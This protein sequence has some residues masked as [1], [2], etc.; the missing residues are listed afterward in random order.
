M[1]NK[2]II[3]VLEDM[4]V[5]ISIPKAAELQ[6]KRNDALN[7]AIGALRKQDV[8]N[9]DAEDM[10]SRQDAISMVHTVLFPK[11]GL[12]KHVGKALMQLPP[13]ERTTGQWLETEGLDEEIRCTMCTNS[14]RSDSGCD[15]SCQYDEKLYKR[16][17]SIIKDHIDG[18]GT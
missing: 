17:M 9:T 3:E 4:K 8:H 1:T 10:I 12:A 14:M 18:G 16:I 11:I 15:G 2:E 7:M 13:V 5:M 6:R